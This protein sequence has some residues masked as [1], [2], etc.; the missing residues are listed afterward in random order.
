[1]AAHGSPYFV[2]VVLENTSTW[3]LAKPA[4][5]ILIPTVAHLPK[6]T[7]M[8]HVVL[9]SIKGGHPKGS[10]EGTLSGFYRIL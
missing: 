3:Q 2:H 9:G 4:K 1:M 7:C 6:L 5:I 10:P 8:V